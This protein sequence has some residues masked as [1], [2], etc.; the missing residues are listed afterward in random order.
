[1][2]ALPEVFR[3]H[4]EYISQ[5]MKDVRDPKIPLQHVADRLGTSIESLCIWLSQPHISE[6][7]DQYE[8]AC[9]RR[10]G[11]IIADQLPNLINMV[12][13]IVT[14]VHAEEQRLASETPSPKNLEARR[15]ARRLA[16]NAIRLLTRFAR[17]K[18]KTRSG[19]PNRTGASQAGASH[20]NTNLASAKLPGTS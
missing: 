10:I 13:T 2:S 1:M 17:F 5:I 15:S 8:C 16:L 7:L 20:A 12:N 6:M 3:P 18:P 19:A 11:L 9:A 14:N 4:P